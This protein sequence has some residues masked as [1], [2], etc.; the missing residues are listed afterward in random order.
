M[1]YCC[2]VDTAVMQAL[3]AAT[4]SVTEQCGRAEVEHARLS[5]LEA[6]L[7]AKHKE[8]E[9]AQVWSMHQAGHQHAGK[10]LCCGAIA[11]HAHVDLALHNASNHGFSLAGSA[12]EC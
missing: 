2:A 11:C 1:T 3:T 10:S 8:L 7:D 5:E 12:L 4:A 9:D 6:L